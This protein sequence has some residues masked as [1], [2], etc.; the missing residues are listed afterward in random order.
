MRDRLLELHTNEAESYK[1]YRDPDHREK[2]KFHRELAPPV[3]FREGRHRGLGW[4]LL[5]FGQ[6]DA[7]S[8]DLA[9]SRSD[10]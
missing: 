2:R 10:P 6:D 4:P 5:I 9:F 8:G 3:A 1:I 7:W